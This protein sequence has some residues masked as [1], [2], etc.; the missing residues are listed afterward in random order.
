MEEATGRKGMCAHVFERT[1]LG[2]REITEVVESY[3]GST[4]FLP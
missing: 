1:W 3:T 4:S 2:T